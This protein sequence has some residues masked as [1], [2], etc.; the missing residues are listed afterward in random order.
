MGAW[1]HVRHRLEAIL[2]DGVALRMVARASASSP[3]TG[4]YH[5]HVEQERTLIVRAFEDV[6][7]VEARESASLAPV[8]EVK[9]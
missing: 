3:A 2:P 7:A 4:Y 8:R 5:M 6:G 1:R 9:P